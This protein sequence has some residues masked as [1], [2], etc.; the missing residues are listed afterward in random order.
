MK[1]FPIIGVAGYMGSG[2]ST[3][4]GMWAEKFEAAY[5]DV[6]S[7]A[8]TMMIED[9]SIVAAVG[10]LFPVVDNGR[11]DFAK[12][13]PIVFSSDAELEKLNHCVHPPLINLLNARTSLLSKEQPV[14]VDAALLTLWEHRVHLDRGIWIDAS[15][16]IRRKRFM[17]RTGLSHDESV[18]RIKKQMELFTC[19]EKGWSMITNEDAIEI[20]F[21]HGV[22]L[23]SEYDNE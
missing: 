20:A 17:E 9:E 8:R 14:I 12:L 1:I 16:E 19:C 21:Q 2:K 5:I 11:I 4:A 23:L 18:K 3:L 7:M 22:A 10:E 15:V 13:G 6:D